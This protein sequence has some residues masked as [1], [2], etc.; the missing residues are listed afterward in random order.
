LSLILAYYLVMIFLSPHTTDANKKRNRKRGHHNRLRSTSLSSPANENVY[1]N[2]LF[3]EGVFFTT[4][5]RRKSI[6]FE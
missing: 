1:S 2:P 3:S 5:M 6:L 4:T